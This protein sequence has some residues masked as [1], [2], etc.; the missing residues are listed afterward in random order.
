MPQMLNEIEWS[1]PLLAPDIDPAWEAEL[2]RRGGNGSEVDRRI[3][4]SVWIREACLGVNTGKA[5]EI[6]A[7]LFNVAALVTSQE[8]A[9]RYCYGANRAYLKMLGYSEAYIRRI[10]TD[11]H[12]AELDEKERALVT[13]CRNLA[14]SR[15]RPARAELEGLVRLGYTPAAAREGALWIALGCF[16]NRVTILLAVPPEQGF[17]QWV[18]MKQRWFTLVG[19]VMRFL[20]ER[21]RR[22]KPDPSLTAAALGAGPYGPVLAPLATPAGRAHHERRAGRR[23]RLQRHFARRQG[24]DVRSRGAQPRLQDQRDRGAPPARRRGLQRSRHRQG[25]VDAAIAAAARGRGAP[26]DLGA[27]HRALPDGAHPGTHARTR[28]SGRRPGRAGGGRRGLARQRHGAPRDAGGMTGLSEAAAWLL[29]AFAVAASALAWAGFRRARLFERLHAETKRKLELLQ[30]EF[31]RFAPADLV[32]RLTEGRGE[33]APQRRQVTMLFADLQGF[34][35]LC[36]RL[37]P[38]LTVTM[39]NDY[40]RHMSEAIQRHHG[41]ITELVGDGLLA[42]FGAPETNP[43]QCRDSVLAALDMRAALAAYNAKLRAQSLPELRFGIGI[44][45]GEVIVGVMGAGE[46]NKFTVTGDPINVASRVESLTR[47]LGVDLLI[48]EEI[49]QGLDERFQLQ[50]ML[51]ARVKG[52]PEPIQTYYVRGT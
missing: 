6:P 3:A 40:F 36:D 52:K 32:E 31:E 20:A 27:R 50:P 44:H 23:F 5:S 30:R 46:L 38:A 14:R 10:E 34:T 4:P 8:N 37:D 2:K 48:T 17:E 47:E 21:R 43:W 35:S 13:F 19:P 12:L 22:G 39:L 7:H 9:C 45:T 42:L 28:R 51:P 11:A 29:A 18:V 15:P 16:Y 49:R 26:A 24:A 1:E 33:V 41:H 25:A